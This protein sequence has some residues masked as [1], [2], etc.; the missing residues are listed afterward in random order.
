MA[1]PVL[2]QL[3][4]SVG[5]NTPLTLAA[6]LSAG[7][8]GASTCITSDIGLLTAYSTKTTVYRHFKTKLPYSL[9][10]F[11][12]SAIAYLIGGLFF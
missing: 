9:M 1:I 3:S 4:A 11:V 12:L 5:A 7:I 2:L 10:A 6:L 8:W